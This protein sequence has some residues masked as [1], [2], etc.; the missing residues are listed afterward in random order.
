MS[1]EQKEKRTY[2]KRKGEW[3]DMTPEEIFNKIVTD[4]SPA[5][6]TVEAGLKTLKRE[7]QEPD[8]ELVAQRHELV[9]MRVR[10]YSRIKALN[11]DVKALRVAHNESL[12]KSGSSL[13]TT[14]VV[15][16]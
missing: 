14:T 2:S 6:K 4:I 10:A 12:S 11:G 13:T 8:A 5:I 15:K 1:E 9:N 16:S 7:G 3:S